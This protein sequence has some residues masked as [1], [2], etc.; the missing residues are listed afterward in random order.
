M[1]MSMVICKPSQPF[2]QIRNSCKSSRPPSKDKV[3]V[4]LGATGTGKSRLSINLATRFHGEVVNADKIQVYEGL[5]VITNKITDEESCGV[6]HHL[7]G[8]MNPAADFTSTDFCDRASSALASVVERR[9]VPIIAGGSNSYIEALVDSKMHGFHSRYDCCYLWLDVSMPVLHQVIS[10]R[11]DV[12]VDKGM[13]EEARQYFNPNGDYSKG[14]RRAIGVPE[15]DYY[16]RVEAFADEETRTRLLQKAIYDVKI[17]SCRL[18]CRQLE[19]ILRLRNDKGWNIY[20]LDATDAL[21]KNAKES[22]K[23]WKELVLEPSMKIVNK[24]LTTP[25]PNIYTNKVPTLTAMAASIR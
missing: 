13:V 20:R 21:Q 6:P 7:L 18:A 2:L 16:F 23:A 19:K 11:V 1:T 15:F 12:M 4:V 8:F 3:V 25:G 5:D 24:F 17:N 10:E 14:I 22:S 9:R